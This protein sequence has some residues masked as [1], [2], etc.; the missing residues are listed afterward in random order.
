VGLQF[1][2]KTLEE[3]ENATKPSHRGSE[4]KTKEEDMLDI[5]AVTGEFSL[6][7]EVVESCVTS[8]L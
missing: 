8:T 6:T 1:A 3:E 4:G 5:T 2:S 7:K